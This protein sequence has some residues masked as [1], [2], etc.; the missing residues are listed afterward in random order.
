MLPTSTVAA[1]HRC[2]V[3]A[4]S[5]GFVVSGH[6]CAVWFATYAEAINEAVKRFGSRAKRA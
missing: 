3:F 6:R 5:H 1:H 4:T 2:Y